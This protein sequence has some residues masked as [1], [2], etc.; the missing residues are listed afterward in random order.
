[1]KRLPASHSHGPDA[2]STDVPP[3]LYVS[4]GLIVFRP[5][6]SNNSLACVQC[7][8]ASETCLLYASD[9]VSITYMIL[10]FLAA[11]NTCRT[12]SLG[13]C[14]TEADVLR[15]DALLDFPWQDKHEKDEETLEALQHSR[16][17]RYREY[18]KQAALQVGVPSPY[19][20]PGASCTTWRVAIALQLNVWLIFHFVAC[21]L[22]FDGTV[23]VRPQQSV[24]MRRAS[25]WTGAE[26]EA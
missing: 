9:S 25:V 19:G 16:P 24:L 6:T 2:I 14:R 26:G 21:I 23:S 5:E 7:N 17:K 22:C 15:D 1:M 4:T 11:C 20:P 12:G 3:D 18:S 13:H 10:S 8:I